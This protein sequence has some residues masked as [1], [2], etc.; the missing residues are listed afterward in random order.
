MTRTAY[1]LPRQQSSSAADGIQLPHRQGGEPEV[2][3]YERSSVA[4]AEA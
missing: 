2:K 4:A 1:T 3:G